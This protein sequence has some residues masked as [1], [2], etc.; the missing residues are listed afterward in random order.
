MCSP[1]LPTSRD[2]ALPLE[3]DMVRVGDETMNGRR[4]SP[5]E[6]FSQ[7]INDKHRNRTKH[8]GYDLFSFLLYNAPIQI[9]PISEDG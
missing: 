1:V 3:V 6:V 4:G 5:S 8:D 2:L 7:E 9:F